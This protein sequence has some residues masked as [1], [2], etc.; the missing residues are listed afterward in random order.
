MILLKWISRIF[1]KV[2][3]M[4][5][6]VYRKIKAEPELWKLAKLCGRIGDI[7]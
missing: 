5:R 4:P 6:K 2:L 3:S 7:T 1:D